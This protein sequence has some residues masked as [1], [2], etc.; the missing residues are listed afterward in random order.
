MVV[1]CTHQAGARFLTVAD[2]FCPVSLSLSLP[3]LQ[4]LRDHRWEGLKR[5]E[6]LTGEKEVLELGALVCK[7]ATYCS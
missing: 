5:F 7:L 4:S 6:G 3:L 1:S 2:S